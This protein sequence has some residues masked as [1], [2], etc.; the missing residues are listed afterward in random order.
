MKKR[1]SLNCAQRLQI[2]TVKDMKEQI[3]KTA[4]DLERL[5]ALHRDSQ[6][7]LETIQAL[8]KSDSENAELRAKQE[9]VFKRAKKNWKDQ[10]ER[11]LKL[12]SYVSSVPESGIKRTRDRVNE[13]LEVIDKR[14]EE[15]ESKLRAEGK[16]DLAIKNAKNQHEKMY[17]VKLLRKQ[18]AEMN[19]ICE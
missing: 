7:T 9:R 3:L 10:L 19:F 4:K 2:N 15:A 13:S 18:L 6:P 11:L 16:Y 12:K 14:W 8:F 17:E 1:L 5:I